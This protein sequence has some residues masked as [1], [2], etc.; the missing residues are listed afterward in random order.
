[1]W[2]AGHTNGALEG[3]NAGGIDA[4]LRAYDADGDLRW[5]RQ[6]GTAATDIAT[7]G[8]AVDGLGRSTVA[9]RTEGALDGPNAGAE[10]AFVRA[11][12]ADGALRWG[13]QFGTAAG[14]NVGRVVVDGAGDVF[15]VGDT[16]GDLDGSNLGVADAF[17]RAFDPAGGTR[18]TRQFG[19]PA[20]DVAAAA[21]LAAGRLAVAGFTLGALAGPNAGS[22]D[23]FVRVFEP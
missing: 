20:G 17:V 12:D 16:D 22:Y 21:A 5:T 11:Y 4:F 10:D 19:S 2:L 13:R 8:V 9:G 6:F 7:G 15:V 23:G 14:E 3:A 18:W 1:V